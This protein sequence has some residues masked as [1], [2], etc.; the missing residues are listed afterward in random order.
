MKVPRLFGLYHARGKV[1]SFEQWLA[2]LF[3]PLFEVAADPNP[4][5]SPSPNPNP[6]SNPNPNPNLFEVAADPSS[7][8]KLHLFLQQARVAHT[9]CVCACVRVCVCVRVCACVCVRVCVCVRARVCVCVCASTSPHTPLRP[10]APPCTPLHPRAPCTPLHPR[11][12]PHDPLP[13]PPTP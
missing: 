9:V 11:A 12:S 10:L 4:S 8:P 3:E 2:N 5:P 13:P 1:V 6:N 7:H